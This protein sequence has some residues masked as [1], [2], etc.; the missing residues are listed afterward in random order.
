[1]IDSNAKGGSVY[2]FSD[3]K[4][5]SVL[6]GSNS[7]V[8][9]FPRQDFVRRQATFGADNSLVGTL[10]LPNG[11][12]K[13]RPGIVI[14]HGSGPQDRNGYASIIALLADNFV[15]GGAVVLT[16][17]KRGVGQSSGDWATASFKS[18]AD[19]ARSGMAFLRSR[20][21]VDASHVGLAGSSQ[22]GWVA[23]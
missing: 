12:Q 11:P 21:E 14:V 10:F 6:T 9:A 13:K 4:Q 1:M 22:A 7:H 20:P 2:D 5:L 15:R 23:A 3:R 17:D 16:Y 18:L 8:S 19:D